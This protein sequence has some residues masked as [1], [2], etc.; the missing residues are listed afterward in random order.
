ML[1]SF[2]ASQRGTVG[3]SAIKVRGSIWAPGV[4]MCVTCHCALVSQ[5]E[6]QRNLQPDPPYPSG[7]LENYR[8]KDTHSSACVVRGRRNTINNEKAGVTGPAAQSQENR[9]VSSISTYIYAL[10]DTPTH[11]QC[12]QYTLQYC[13]Q[14]HVYTHSLCFLHPVGSVLQL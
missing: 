9:R 8:R 14:T 6:G 2:C 4:H 5:E 13:T 11:I 1:I 10:T 7:V 3:R 12:I